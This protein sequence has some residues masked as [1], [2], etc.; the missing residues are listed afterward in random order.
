MSNAKY[1]TDDANLTS[2]FDAE[3][4]NSLQYK[5]IGD[6][7]NAN[8]SSGVSG[9]LQDEWNNVLQDKNDNKVNRIFF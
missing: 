2:L 5:T 3:G 4:T 9:A 7:K 6:S 8:A 1:N